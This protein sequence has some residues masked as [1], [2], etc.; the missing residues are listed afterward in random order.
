MLS[1]C[2]DITCIVFHN[3]VQTKWWMHSF[4]LCDCMARHLWK[5]GD[6]V[7]SLK[8]ARPWK[9]LACLKWVPDK[10]GVHQEFKQNPDGSSDKPSRSLQNGL[11]EDESSYYEFFIVLFFSWIFGKSFP[12]YC[13]F[14]VFIFFELHSQQI[15]CEVAFTHQFMYKLTQVEQDMIVVMCCSYTAF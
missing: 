9:S 8:C 5:K 12:L 11:K 4:S 14:F 2:D 6:P 3:V 13:Y 15:A 10:R 7:L 1:K